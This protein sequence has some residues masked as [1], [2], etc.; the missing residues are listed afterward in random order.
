MT[1]P[2]DVD[3]DVEARMRKY[4]LH[5]GSCIGWDIEFIRQ[6]HTLGRWQRATD[7]GWENSKAIP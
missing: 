4:A 7:Y 3:M 1:N 5:L 2:R 6:M